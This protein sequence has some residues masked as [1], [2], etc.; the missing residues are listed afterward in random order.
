[1]EFCNTMKLDTWEEQE[2]FAELA[3][4]FEF[5]AGYSRQEAEQAAWKIIQREYH[6]GGRK[7]SEMK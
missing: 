7:W 5:D 1:M 2:R 4:K 6:R 3:G